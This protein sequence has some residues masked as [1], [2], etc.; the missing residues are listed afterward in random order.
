MGCYDNYSPNLFL[1]QGRDLKPGI[2]KALGPEKAGIFVER[3]TGCDWKCWA[4]QP[5]CVFWDAR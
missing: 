1:Q 4:T 5:A 2:Q 3:T